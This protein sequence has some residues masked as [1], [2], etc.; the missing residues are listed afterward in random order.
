M[1]LVLKIYALCSISNLMNQANNKQLSPIKK[2]IYLHGKPFFIYSKINTHM[3]L[4]INET[5]PDFTAET[6]QGRIQVHEWLGDSWGILFSHPKEKRVVMFIHPDR[7]A[8]KETQNH[9]F[10]AIAQLTKKI[11]LINKR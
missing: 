4:R 7:M 5:A 2:I 10:F 8:T 9:F 6:T 11:R 1:S 3:S